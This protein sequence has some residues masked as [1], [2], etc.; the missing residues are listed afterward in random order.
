MSF[1]EY[2][3]ERIEIGKETVISS[4]VEF[5][6]DFTI[7][8]KGSNPKYTRGI[9]NPDYISINKFMNMMIEK[10]GEIV[11]GGW[12]H[13][14]IRDDTFTSFCSEHIHENESGQLSL[15]DAYEYYKTWYKNVNISLSDFKR[16]ME[17]RY[18]AITFR[19]FNGIQ[20]R[21]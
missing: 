1:D 12:K 15:T 10:Y 21:E 2:C 14:H 4:I 7:W 3:Q 17:C 6:Y 20:I 18:G 13:I 8:S 16:L 5:Y 11:N 9:L 19:K